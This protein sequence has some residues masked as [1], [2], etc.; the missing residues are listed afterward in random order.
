MKLSLLSAALI[1]ALLAWAPAHAD[2]QEPFIWVRGEVGASLGLNGAPNDAGVGGHIAGEAM[3]YVVHPLA[4]AVRAGGSYFSPFQAKPDALHASWSGG[5][6]LRLDRFWLGGFAGM[7]ESLGENVFGVDAELGYDLPFCANAGWGPF[8]GYSM[9]M[10]D[11]PLH[12]IQAGLSMSLGVPWQSAAGDDPDHDGILGAA[13]ACPTDAEDLDGNADQD[14][15]PEADD[16]DGD[17][18]LDAAD[19]CPTDAEDPDG[20]QDTDGCPDADNDADHV[21]D[22]ADGAPNDAEDPDG[23]QDA[24]G[25]PDPDNDLDLVLDAADGAPLVPEDRDGFEDTDGVPDPDND[26][27]TVLDGDDQCPTAPGTP[28]AHG[29]PQ[30]VRVEAGRITILQRI[31]FATG[32]ATLLPSA[33]AILEEIRAA[34]AV[35]PQI[36]HVRVEGH[37]DDRGRAPH[38]LELS[39]ARAETVVKWLSDHQ[40]AADRLEALGLGQTR[41]LAPNTTNANRQTNRRV[42]FIITDPAPAPADSVAPPAAPPAAASPPAAPTEAAPAAPAAQ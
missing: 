19:Q 12:F 2:A 6:V 13:D 20:F 32:R 21:L 27:D 5:L 42:E 31:E 35:N 14:G 26:Q 29:C 39:Q 28:A 9:A 37:T 7:H 16:R 36:R 23:F 3:V 40:I 33:A 18:V 15:C 17:G 1:A 22:A 24:D 4:I 8:V 41:P 10:L 30:A 25:V 38:N 11:T 34:L